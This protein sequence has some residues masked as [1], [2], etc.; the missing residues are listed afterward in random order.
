MK[1]GMVTYFDVIGRLDETFLPNQVFGAC[2]VELPLLIE[3]LFFEEVQTTIWLVLA[4]C[5]LT[6]RSVRYLRNLAH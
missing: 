5:H 1:D 6:N 4:H 3:D 2:L